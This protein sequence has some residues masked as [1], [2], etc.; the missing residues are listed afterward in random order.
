MAKRRVYGNHGFPFG[1]GLDA[2][3]EQGA[4]RGSDDEAHPGSR[5]GGD[6][7]LVLMREQV[8]QPLGL[9]P[10]NQE[11]Q[12]PHMRLQVEAHLGGQGLQAHACRARIEKP[13]L[14]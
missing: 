2:M 8:T 11:G 5:H 10:F 7:A 9:Q 4:R 1:K 13:L 3:D 14:P 12:V 6:E